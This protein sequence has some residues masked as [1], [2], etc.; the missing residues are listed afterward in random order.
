MA[1]PSDQTDSA[2]DQAAYQSDD[3]AQL[4]ALRAQATQARIQLDQLALEAA[5]ASENYFEAQDLLEATLAAIEDAEEE[6]R[7]N[8]GELDRVG[9]LL[10]DRAVDSYQNGELSFV[11]FLFGSS[12]IGDLIARINLLVALMDNDA[13]MILEARQLRADIEH[14]RTQ[15]EEKRELE[16][17]AAETAQLEFEIVQDSLGQQESLLASLDSEVHR[18]IEEERAAIEAE[19]LRI[20][21]QQQE[22]DERARRAEAESGQ[23]SSAQS[24]SSANAGSASSGAA[25]PGNS[26]GSASNAG[27]GNAGS[28]NAGSGSGSGNNAGSGNTNNSSP[29]SGSGN[30]NANNAGSGNSSAG[31]GNTAGSGS[32]SNSNPPANQSPSLGRERPGAVTAA[33][34]QIGVPYLWGGTTPAGFDC[35]GLVQFA[36]REAYGIN[37]PRTSRQQFHAGV[38]IPANRMDLM[39]PGDLVFFSST[40]HPANIHHVGI[41]IGN[42]RM[43]HAPQPGTTVREQV[44]WR[45]DFIGAV[46]P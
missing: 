15:L 24:S 2:Q 32:G 12:D 38:H 5:I 44:I 29:G 11:S 3:A 10:A 41:F 45:H 43:I 26:S 23:G 13:E 4:G 46:R 6:L 9:D 33:R 28:A 20:A 17:E 7:L 31:S 35:S 34:R 25:T 18:L 8:Q 39:R 40:G 36:Y 19:Q 16:R 1:S 42:N 30:N 21:Q 27:S 14:T 37:L 22:E